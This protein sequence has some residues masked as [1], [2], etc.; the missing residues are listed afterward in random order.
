ML[1][2]VVL[3]LASLE[4]TIARQRSRI[5]WLQG[6]ASTKLFHLVANGRKTKKFIPAILH[7]GNLITDQHGKEEIFFQTY[8]N[9]LGSARGRANT[10]DLEFLGIQPVDLLD[11]DA[12]FTEEEVLAT[13]KDM[14]ADR[15]PGPDGFIG[16]F[17]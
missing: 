5:R 17:F 7:D 10:I 13:I 12:Y 8:K 11:Q 16:L 9:L 4:H 1:K 14:P 2:L 15:A 6:D 3:G